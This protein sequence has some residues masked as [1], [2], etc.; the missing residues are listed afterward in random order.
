[1]VIERRVTRGSGGSEE[2]S[3]EVCGA[4]AGREDPTGRQMDVEGDRGRT[5]VQ[6]E[7]GVEET[8]PGPQDMGDPCVRKGLTQESP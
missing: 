6:R 4:G 8:A 1:M 2:K 7:K 3:G 5:E